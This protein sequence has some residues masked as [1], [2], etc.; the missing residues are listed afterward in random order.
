LNQSVSRKARLAAVFEQVWRLSA[1]L[2]AQNAASGYVAMAWISLLSIVT[3]PLY[4]RLLGP[5]E[6][7]MVA[8][9]ASLQIFSN[10]IDSGFSQIVPRWAAHEANN[11]ERLRQYIF[12]FRKLYIGLGLLLFLVLQASAGYLSHHWFQV[13][14]QGRHELELM[15]RIISFQFLFQFVN[16]L[17]IGLWIGLQRQVLANARTCGF[18]TLKH[19]AALIALMMWTPKGWLYAL[20]FATVACLELGINS[21]TVNNIL[22]KGCQNVIS[23][24]VA[25]GPLLKEVSV[26][27]S[28][29]LVGLLVSQLD[30][31]ILSHTV[32]LASFGIYMVVLSLALG[33]L[34][35]QAPVSRAFFPIIVQDIKV[36]GHVKAIHMRYM[37][38]GVILTS[39]LPALLA[40][41][42]APQI[43]AVWL[44]NPRVE[45]IA[46]T[47]LRLMLIAVA[48]NSLANCIYPLI[49]AKG[50]SKRI[51]QFN[52]VALLLSVIVVLCLGTSWGLALGGAI[53]ISNGIVQSS[54]GMAW[55]I[56]NR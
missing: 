42:F 54:L 43:L 44:H 2:P 9:C 19:F 6:W 33:L 3:I 47:P 15:I 37:A 48:L 23:G 38:R 24:S 30:R 10:F 16:N 41:L 55:F 31:I 35:L 46:I 4:I 32:S 17:N 1:S 22:G 25:L 5:S 29:I 56:K 27:S 20:V 28:G 21:L 34:S 52:L 26:L 18:G 12:L 53:W 40:C 8:A 7:G 11:P 13:I 49:I 50:Q 14:G 36:H 45:L 39:A 51:L